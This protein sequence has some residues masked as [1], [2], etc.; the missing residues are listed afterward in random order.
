MLQTN[1]TNA[2]GL[3][4]NMS[5]TAYAVI[6]LSRSAPILTGVSYVSDSVNVKFI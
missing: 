4:M 2:D 6:A 5:V 1:L 3:E